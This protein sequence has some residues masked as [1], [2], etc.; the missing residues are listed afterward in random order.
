MGRSSG[1]SCWQ[2]RP[3]L[4]L[5]L[6]SPAGRTLTEGLPEKSAQ[7]RLIRKSDAK[8]YVAQRQRAGYHQMA[9]L[10]QPPLDDVGMRRFSKGQLERPRE[11]R[12]APPRHDTQVLGVN[13]SVQV[14]VDESPHPRDLPARQPCG[15]GGLHARLAFDLRLQD[16]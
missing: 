9:G 10:L 3:L 4:Y 8:R 14:L 6:A 12:R 11:V 7:M 15:S 2:R 16:G 13:G 1:C 5:A